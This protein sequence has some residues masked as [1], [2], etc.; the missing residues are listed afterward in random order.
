MPRTREEILEERRRL[1][2][3]HGELFDPISALLFR[4][5]PVEINFGI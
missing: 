4:H 2:S 5:D 1:N 3:E